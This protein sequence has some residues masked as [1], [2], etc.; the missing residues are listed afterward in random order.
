[1]PGA[2]IG[3]FAINAAR[4]IGNNGK[5]I[6]IEPE[7]VNFS[8]LLKNIETN[9]LQNIIA[10]RKMLWSCKAEIKLYLFHIQYLA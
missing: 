9:G 10:V 4:S 6:A 2:R 1:M 3:T 7:P 5:V 8:Y